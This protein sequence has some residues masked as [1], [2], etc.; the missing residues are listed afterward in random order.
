M[1]SGK[2]LLITGGTAPQPDFSVPLQIHA[3]AELF[4]PA[5]GSFSPAG[6][7]TVTR[8]GH[9]AVRLADGRVLVAGGRDP[10]PGGAEADLFDPATGT[11]RR[12]A[13]VP[14]RNRGAMVLLADGRVLHTGGHPIDTIDWS[15]EARIYDPAS[16]TDTAISAMR[17]GRAEHAMTLLGD[18]RVL[19]TGGAPL[20]V[21]EL[22]DPA[23]GTF[24]ITAPTRAFRANHAAVRLGDGRVLI[25]GH[26]GQSPPAELFIP[27]GP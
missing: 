2:T 4:D 19:V 6:E 27:A 11:F 5:T 24:T 10:G 3:S 22:F 17:Y 7:M 26:G 23:T 14:L 21:A 8:A 13:D 18:G 25:F 9:R 20:L 15:A 1:F 16:E 12:T